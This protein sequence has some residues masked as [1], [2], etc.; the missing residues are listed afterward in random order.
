MKKKTVIIAIVVIVLVSVAGL[1]LILHFRPKE[2]PTPEEEIPEVV[3]E[4]V[5]LTPEQKLLGT[6]IQT[7][8]YL[9][10]ANENIHSASVTVTDKEQLIFNEDGSCVYKSLYWG[11]V[12]FSYELRE[13]FV[14]MM[15]QGWAPQ[16]YKVEDTFLIDPV[17]NVREYEKQ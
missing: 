3:E 1:L 12:V 6:W 2:I 10:Y 5:E 9:D 15:T 14:I 13:G 17:I 16:R 7:Q 11:D 8:E 4:V